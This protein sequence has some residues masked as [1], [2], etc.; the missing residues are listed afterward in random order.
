[1]QPE[2]KLTIITNL[3]ELHEVTNSKTEL[4]EK[5]INLYIKAVDHY[6]NTVWKFRQEH[7][8][9]AFNNLLCTSKYFPVPADL[10]E[11][12]QKEEP[13]QKLTDEEKERMFAQCED[14]EG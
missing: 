12:L 13:V 10:I 2:V 14:Y 3:K 6:Y 1:M 9:L 8:E 11:E 5:K 4:T 7:L